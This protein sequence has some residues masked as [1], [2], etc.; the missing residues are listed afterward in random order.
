[1]LTHKKKYISPSCRYFGRLA[2]PGW[3]WSRCSRR[4]WCCRGCRGSRLGGAQPHVTGAARTLTG[5]TGRA[6]G[7]GVPPSW[8]GLWPERRGARGRAVHI[9][10]A[11]PTLTAAPR[12]GGLEVVL[13]VPVRLRSRFG[14]TPGGRGL[15]RTRSRYRGDTGRT[16]AVRG[17]VDC[18][19]V[20][21]SNN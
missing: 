7:A 19:V 16:E 20:V 18:S 5:A 15:L 1:M 9:P 13:I 21:T 12:S 3:R 11:T 17:A 2:V 14:R 6:L 4:M 10:R 8:P